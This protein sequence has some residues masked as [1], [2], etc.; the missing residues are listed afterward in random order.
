MTEVIVNVRIR[1][2]ISMLIEVLILRRFI[3]YLC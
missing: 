3:G 1:M 2:L